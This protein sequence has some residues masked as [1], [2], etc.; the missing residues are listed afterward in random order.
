[1]QV[2]ANAGTFIKQ[3][4]HLFSVLGASQFKSHRGLGGHQLGDF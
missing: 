2:A 3:I 1:M 4:S